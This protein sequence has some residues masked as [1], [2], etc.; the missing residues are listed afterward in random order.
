MKKP[1]AWRYDSRQNRQKF[2]LWEQIAV[3]Q[4]DRNLDEIALASILFDARRQHDKVVC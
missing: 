2:Q 3:R 1:K 4:A